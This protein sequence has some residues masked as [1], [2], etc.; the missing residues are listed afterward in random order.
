MDET[1]PTSTN[2]GSPVDVPEGNVAQKE[3]SG[4]ANFGKY[5][6]DLCFVPLRQLAEDG[7]TAI[8]PSRCSICQQWTEEKTSRF[9]LCLECFRKM[10]CDDHVCRRCS[11]PLPASVPLLDDCP[12]CRKEKWAF[13]R[14]FCFGTYDHTLRTAVIL[15]KRP[16]F[17]SLSLG[18]GRALAESM[19]NRI[20][21]PYDAVIPTPQHWI[22]RVLSRNNSS[23][24]IAESISANLRFPFRRTWLRRIRA[25][26]KQGMLG[27][28]QRRTNV[29][30]ACALS[31]F[32]RVGQRRIL[33]VDDILTS[34]S[35]ANEM[36]RV[37]LQAGAEFVDIAAVARSLG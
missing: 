2:S 15:M 20:D 33:L 1:I 37:L 5:L 26:K 3:T 17:E 9:A 8:F 29:R 21:A 19:R 34:G 27:A 32:A 11:A 23:E 30:N 18:L 13:R 12:H 6:S 25:T 35:T 28:E 31:P 7:L 14:A 24:L 10:A 22:K 36:A 16:Y 4:Q